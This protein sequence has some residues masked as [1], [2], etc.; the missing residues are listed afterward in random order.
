MAS[1]SNTFKVVLL[2][3]GRVGK[4]SLVVRFCKDTFADG[5][6]PTIQASCLER[7]MRVAEQSVNLVIW[8]TAGQERFHALGPIYY[9]DADAALLVFDIT[10]TDSFN[11]ARNWVKEL[12]KMVA[13]PALEPWPVPEPGHEAYAIGAARSQVGSE[14]VLTLVGNKCDLERQRVVPRAQATEYAE[15][16]GAHYCETSAKQGRGIDDAF[17]SLARRL[18][19]ARASKGAAAESNPLRPRSARAA[20]LVVDDEPVS[21]AAGCC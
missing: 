12:R 19:H 4:T 1:R 7:A 21:R 9:R 5:Q 18:L 13:G 15:S 14:I 17:S 10:D 20:P 16:V 3:E 11:R 6:A 8:D 2:G